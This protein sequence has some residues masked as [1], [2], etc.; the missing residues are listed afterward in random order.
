MSR[1][2]KAALLASVSPHA[3]DYGRKLYYGWFW[4]ARRATE[5]RR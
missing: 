3:V 4:R 5:G 1:S 2:F